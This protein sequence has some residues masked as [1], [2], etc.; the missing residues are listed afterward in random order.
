METHV[1]V[2]GVLNIVCGVVGLLLAATL[3][4]I[5]GGVLAAVAAEGEADAAIALPI[6]GLTGT[7]LVTFLAVLSLPAFIVGLGLC[8]LKP[9]AR[10]GGI[11]VAIMSLFGFPFGTALGIYG[12]WVLFA[13]DTERLFTAPPL[14]T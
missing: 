14:A 1:K 13:K 4:L 12:L 6:I 7:A 5:F 3:M 10:I 8:R 9:W 11:I 2:L